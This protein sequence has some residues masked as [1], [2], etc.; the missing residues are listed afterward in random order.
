MADVWLTAD[1]HFSHRS[2]VERGW[3]PQYPTV[4]EMDADLIDRWNS[5]VH[6]GDVVWHLGDFALGGARRALELVGVLHGTIHVIAGNHDPVWP[7]RRDS[8]KH[9]AVW[10][11]AGFASVQAFARRRLPGGQQVLL[12]HFPYEGDHRDEERHPEYRLRDTGLPL[13]HGHVHEAWRIRGRQ[14]N[15]GVD[16]RGWAPVH[17]DVLAAEVAAA[18]PSGRAEAPDG[19]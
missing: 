4:A 11:A 6:P 18:V 17:L 12:S 13:L 16:V 2:M 8:H 5:T 14:I 9:Q 10:L 1:T 7:A 3:R 15:V 19:A